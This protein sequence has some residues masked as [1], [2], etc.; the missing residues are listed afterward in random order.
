[1]SKNKLRSVN[2]KFWD[3]PFIEELTPSDKLLFLYLL[4]NPLTNLL[5]VYE[6]TIK[7]I[8]FDTGLN[9]ETIKKG[10]ERFGKVRK[11]FFNENFVILP[12][13]LKNQNLNYNMKVAVVREFKQLPNWLKNNIVGNGEEGFSN[14]SEGFETLME[15]FGKYEREIEREIEDESIN[16]SKSFTKNDVDDIYKLYPSKCPIRKASSNKCSKDKDKIES[17]LKSGK[18]VDEFKESIKKYISGCIETKTY[19]KNFKTFLSNMPDDQDMEIT[20]S[21]SEKPFKHEE[22]TL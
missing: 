14:G 6:I 15:R 11:A 5:G 2:T 12:N 1:M 22:P 10:F 7:R 16:D 3:D 18:T 9:Q 4:T 8:S 21:E 17:I 20:V 19:V 13:W